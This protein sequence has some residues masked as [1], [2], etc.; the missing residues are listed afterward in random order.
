MD[1]KTLARAYDRSAGGY[2]ERFRALQRPKYEAAARLLGGLPRGP[3]LDA[4]GGTGLF[5]EFA[6]EAQLTVLDASLEMLRCARARGLACVQGDLAAPPFRP[7]SF[8]LVVSF[9]AVLSQ[10]PRALQAL[11]GLVAPGGH[12]IVSFLGDEAP[13]AAAV[14]RHAGLALRAGPIE[15]GQDRVFHV[16]REG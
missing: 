5:A 16:T 14:A 6:P 12:L 9:T 15:A 1:L 13:A 2:D 10:V 4:G 11:G 7:R 8:P 3:C